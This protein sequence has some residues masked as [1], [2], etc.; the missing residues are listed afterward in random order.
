MKFRFI[1]NLFI[2]LIIVKCFTS[3]FPTYKATLVNSEKISDGEYYDIQ[4]KVF[5]TDNT[6]SLFKN[7][8][9]VQNKSIRS[10]PV[11]KKV[12]YKRDYFDNFI[13]PFDSI[14]AIVLY[15]ETT[16]PGRYFASFFF[17]LTAPA[18]TFLGVYCI[19]CPKCCFG[20]CPT[21]YTFDGKH[22]NLEV[23]LF[24][25]C[26]SKQIEDGD[27]DLLQQKITNDSLLLKIT[28]EALE[29]HYVNKFDLLVAEHLI[30]T[31]IYPNTNNDLTII[32]NQNFISRALDKN[33]ADVTSLL[34]N[35]DDKFYR[36]GVNSINELKNGVA[37]DWIDL[38]LPVQKNLPSKIILKYRNTLLSTTLLYDVVIGSQ[39]ID[40]LKWT[41][42][43]N[44]DKYYAKQFKMIYDL[45]SGIKIK[46]LRN[47]VWVE[48]GKFKDAGPLNWK[49][50][51]AEL[52]AND[53][54][55]LC[56][57]LEFIPDNFMIDY[58]G[59]DTIQSN[60]KVST[61]VLYPSQV[62]DGNGNC[63]DSLLN[64]IN[65]DDSKY[66]KTEPGDSYTLHYSI[67]P[68]INSEQTFLISS[69]GYYNEWI[70]GSWING[71]NDS[72]SFN[73]YDVNGTLSQLA[74]S[75]IENSTILEREFF[76]SKFSLK[77]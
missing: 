21:V 48:I 74:K 50:L 43:M 36:S 44:E 63:S 41:N 59:I 65:N 5:K 57:R 33:G 30:G 23:E 32:S 27:T 15:E 34:L 56:V 14:A 68:K 47:N 64:Y 13:I 16:S 31:K 25:E 73:L 61:R 67:S 55:T 66:L 9:I 52:P 72:Y 20:S 40:G 38:E 6:I 39:G 17:G 62:L 77:E 2:G 24:S 7:G 70:R 53:S 69:K 28:N 49:Y 37:Y 60:Y 4:A 46:V 29:T 3:C 19:A 11:D 75:W 18:L 58:I 71:S 42:K 51:V 12:S 10:K 22:Y 1:K 45:F 76:H 8:F 54:N 35:D 26:I